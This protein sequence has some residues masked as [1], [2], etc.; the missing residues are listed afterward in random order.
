MRSVVRNTK[1]SY[2][3]SASQ[4]A[5]SSRETGTKLNNTRKEVKIQH[6]AVYTKWRKESSKEQSGKTE[7]SLV[8][9]KVF[10]LQAMG[11]STKVSEQRKY[12]WKEGQDRRKDQKQEILLDLSYW[13]QKD[14]TMNVRR[15]KQKIQKNQHSQ[16]ILCYF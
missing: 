15:R 3:D 10:I 8:H 14:L 6:D 4:G 9:N 16:R 13:R 2:K 11:K 1:I 12:L 7:G 5:H